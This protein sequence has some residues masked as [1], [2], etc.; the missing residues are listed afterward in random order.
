MRDFL[1]KPFI[2]KS[3]WFRDMKI[4]EVPAVIP[5][6]WALNKFDQDLTPSAFYFQP[7]SKVKHK[8]HFAF[9]VNVHC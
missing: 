9:Y 1:W 6:K 4:L 2:G 3:N 7:M 8:R 5:S